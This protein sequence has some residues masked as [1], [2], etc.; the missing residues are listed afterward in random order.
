MRVTLKNKQ[1]RQ[2][3]DQILQGECSCA[4]IS[5][6][7]KALLGEHGTR[8]A[9]L[10]RD[11]SIYVWP[12]ILQTKKFCRIMENKEELATPKTNRRHRKQL[13]DGNVCVGQHTCSVLKTAMERTLVLVMPTSLDLTYSGW[14]ERAR[15]AFSKVD[16]FPMSIQSVVVSLE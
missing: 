1:S 4:R 3:T 16:L 15:K 12:K 9:L 10:V 13:C 14:V 11:M 7:M 5:I 6:R 8:A 2:A